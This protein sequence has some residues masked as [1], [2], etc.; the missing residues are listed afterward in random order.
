MNKTIREIIY[1]FKDLLDKE[2]LGDQTGYSNRFIYNHMLNYRATLI[3]RKRLQNKLTDLNY[4]SYTLNLEEVSDAEFPCVDEGNCILLRSVEPIPDY[5]KL[6]SITTPISK[7]GVVEKLSNINPDLAKYKSISK[8][9]KTS[10]D[11]YYFLRTTKDGTYVYIW[12]ETPIFL[13]AIT[14]TAIFYR[15]HEV[16]ALISCK[17]TIDPCYNYLDAKFPIDPELLTD[18]YNLAINSLLRSKSQLSDNT[19]DGLEINLGNPAVYK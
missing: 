9:K 16:E 4:Q 2:R 13:Q 1:D 10:K 8:L 12:S 18:I 6:K 14:I 7:T 15:P 19:N 5:I 17:G 3:D 11:K